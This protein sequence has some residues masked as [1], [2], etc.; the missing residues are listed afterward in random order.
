MQVGNAFCKHVRGAANVKVGKGRTEK[1]KLTRGGA[2]SHLKSYTFDVN[3]KTAGAVYAVT[4]LR[5]GLRGTI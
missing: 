2:I 3:H 5:T 4:T 1:R